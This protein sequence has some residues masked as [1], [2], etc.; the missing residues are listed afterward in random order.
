MAVRSGWKGYL[1]LSLVSIP[2]RSYTA[3]NS[4]TSSGITLNQLHEKCHS[5]IKYV[6]TCPL[7]GEVSSDEIVSGYEYSKGEYAVID[8]SELEALRTEADRA[9]S[10]L[11]VVPAKEVDPLYFGGRTAY[12]LPDG[13]IGQK[14]YALVQRALADLSL[15]A[16]AQVVLYGKEETVVLRPVEQLI[17]MTPINYEN[18][19]THPAEFESELSSQEWSDSEMKMTRTLLDTM[20]QKRF[21]IADYKDLYA[22]RLKTL[23]E[24]KVHG[25]KLVRPDAVDEAPHVINLMDALRQSVERAQ[26]RDTVPARSTVSVRSAAAKKKIAKNPPVRAAARRRRKSG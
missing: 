13:P 9:V 24:A 5:R 20:K 23:V 1:R 7:H 8:P 2:V 19:V 15:F 6:K 17:A 16:V 22:E 14:P 26:G 10:I 11:S 4:C 18:E 25:Q 21:D 12:L 3:V